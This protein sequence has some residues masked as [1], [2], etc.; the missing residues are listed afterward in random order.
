MDGNGLRAGGTVGTV[1]SIRKILRDFRA[2]NLLV[3]WD[4]EGGSQRR[5]AIFKEYKAGR[6]IRVNRRDDDMAETP[7]QQLANLREQ[8][9][10]AKDFLGLLGVPQVRCDGVEADDV[11]AFL[12][13]REHPNGC[14][15]VSTDQDMLQLIRKFEWTTDHCSESDE[16]HGRDSTG[17]CVSCRDELSLRSVSV[18]SPVKEIFYDYDTFKDEMKILPENFRFCKALMGDDSDNIPGIRGYGLA[19]IVKFF[20]ELTERILTLDEFRALF[21]RPKGVLGD[22]LRSEIA[23]FEQNMLLM[24]LSSPMISATSAFHA[25]EALT[26][27]T[28]LNELGFRTRTVAEQISFGSNFDT[29]EFRDFGLRRKKS[30]G[31][32]NE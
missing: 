26:G 19:T 3:V 16:G 6:T 1:L 18:W 5:K 9:Q 31:A 10:K 23:R 20:P 21:V 4:G 24:D 7:E 22:R 15:I 2:G 14:V 8:I 12:A 29:R 25:A 32:R 27:V 28:E 17:I 11:I 30:L 13:Q